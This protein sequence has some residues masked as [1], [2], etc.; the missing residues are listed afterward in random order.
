[1][2]Q[3]LSQPTRTV[4][5]ITASSTRESTL[6]QKKL[7]GNWKRFFFSVGGN[8]ELKMKNILY[9]SSKLTKPKGKT[10]FLSLHV[11]YK[12]YGKNFTMFYSP[13]MALNVYITTQFQWNEIESKNYYE[14]ERLTIHRHLV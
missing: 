6:G 7:H 9:I 13:F 3:K 1:M 10:K 11:Q 8:H 5:Q 2:S 4:N 14:I 12:S